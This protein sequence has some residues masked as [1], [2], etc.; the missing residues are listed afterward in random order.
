MRAAGHHR[1]G[2]EL[3]NECAG[4][5]LLIGSHR[6]RAALQHSKRVCVASLYLGWSRR[7]VATLPVLP[8]PSS[9]HLVDDGNAD[10][11]IGAH[12]P[13]QDLHVSLVGDVVL[14]QYTA[15]A[16]LLP[17]LVAVIVLLGLLQSIAVRLP[18]AAL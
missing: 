17:A 14:K 6:H 15:G 1:D 4:V 18:F 12:S 16:D 9:I 3:I 10:F 7:R 2:V 13:H 5:G 11:H 8:P